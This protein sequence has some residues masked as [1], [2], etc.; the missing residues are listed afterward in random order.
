MSGI[1]L[2]RTY[3]WTCNWTPP[4]HPSPQFWR[5]CDREC[6]HQ[7][8]S[9]FLSREC[10]SL[11]YGWSLSHLNFWS[12]LE[13]SL[14]SPYY[15]WSFSRQKQESVELDR[16]EECSNN[17]WVKSKALG[18]FD[19]ILPTLLQFSLLP[20]LKLLLIPKVTP[21][22]RIKTPFSDARMS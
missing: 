6:R 7:A 15:R 2:P 3:T 5:N 17:M 22:K 20:R 9:A 8:Q 13:Y 11:S 1:R 16:N 4:T 21:V 19:H 12:S 14:E 10:L 18:N